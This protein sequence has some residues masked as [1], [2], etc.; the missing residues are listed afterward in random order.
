LLEEV[1]YTLLSSNNTRREI[2][3]PLTSRPIAVTSVVI[4]ASTALLVAG[5]TNTALGFVVYYVGY[6]IVSLFA[7]GGNSFPDTH[8]RLVNL[9]VA[10]VNTGAF[11]GAAS[12]VLLPLR[13][14]S[15]AI[16]WVAAAVAAIVYLALLLVFVRSP[17]FI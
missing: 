13:T 1:T 12:L 7:G 6:G 16:R 10:C 17:I 5:T 4:A 15:L 2:R 9:V 8:H 14:R 3:T 11:A